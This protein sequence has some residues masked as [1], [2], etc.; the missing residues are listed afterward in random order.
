[1]KQI[2]NSGLAC[3]QALNGRDG[4]VHS[5]VGDVRSSVGNVHSSVEIDRTGVTDCKF[6]EPEHAVHQKASSLLSRILRE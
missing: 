6:G 1:M 3:A 4:D 5:S 2:T